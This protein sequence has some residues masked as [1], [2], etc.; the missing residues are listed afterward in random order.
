MVT[1]D[2][3]NEEDIA[4]LIIPDDQPLPGDE[5]TFKAYIEAKVYDKEGHLIQ[6]HRQPMRSLTQYF[7]AL[8]SIPIQ[9]TS[10]SSTANQAPGILTNVLGLPSEVTNLAGPNASLWGAANITWSWSIQLGSGTQAFSLSLTSLA[11]P[12]ANG[13]GTGELVYG[14]LS[15]SYAGASI[16]ISVTV[17]NYTTSTV[18]VTE[19]GLVGTV[20]LNY[21][22]SSDQPTISPYNFLLSYD[23]FST[24]I[25]IPAGSLAAFQ[26]TISFSG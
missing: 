7:L 8:M 26:I 19:I 16:Y 2:L 10:Q 5:P 13:T 25:S 11:A 14:S 12:I 17:S 24:A 23:T 20:D 6:Y 9:G 4:K 21:Y 22:N 18:N 1:P 3:A 15:I